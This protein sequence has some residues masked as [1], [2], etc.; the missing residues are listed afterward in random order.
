[1]TVPESDSALETLRPGFPY[2]TDEVLRTNPIGRF[3]VARTFITPTAHINAREMYDAY[4][5]WCGV[6]RISPVTEHKF[7]QT[8]ARWGFCRDDNGIRHLSLV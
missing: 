2:V 5:K 1:M 3:L 7:L 4:C 6:K 8:L